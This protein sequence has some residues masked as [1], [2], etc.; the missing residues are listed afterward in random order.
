MRATKISNEVLAA[1]SA[2]T[3]EGREMRLGGQLDRGVYTK[4]KKIIEDL[5]GRWER[6]AAAHIFEG[7]AAEAIEPVLLTGTIVRSVDMGQFD[8]PPDVVAKVMELAEI[9]PGHVVLE[10]S[11]G[12][13]NLLRAIIDAGAKARWCE[14]DAKRHA[15][16]VKEFGPGFNGDFLSLDPDRPDK[17]GNPFRFDRVVMNPPFAPSQADI[18]HVMHA[19]RFLKPGGRLVSVMAGGVI[20]RKNRRTSDFLEFITSMVHDVQQLPPASFKA[21]GTNVNT[22]AVRFTAPL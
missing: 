2:A 19:A 10:P 11:A 21:S 7:D 3:F 12:K 22:V 8:S 20:F 15:A 17:Q 4:L 1:L 16:L 18:A 6:K 9:E 13:G 5:G 14:I